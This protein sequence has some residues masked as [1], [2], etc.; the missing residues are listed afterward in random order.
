MGNT[1]DYNRRWEQD[2]REHRRQ[3]KKKWRRENKN[4]SSADIICPFFISETAMQI[5]CESVYVNTKC[6][7]HR[8]KSKELKDKHRNCFCGS[9]NYQKCPYARQL[10]K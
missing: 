6:D 3:Y 2:H 4:K 10:N 1:S 5:T 9:F 8:F 7:I